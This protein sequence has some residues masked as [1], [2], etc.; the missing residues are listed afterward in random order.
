MAGIIKS[1]KLRVSMAADEGLLFLTSSNGDGLCS[2]GNGF[3]GTVRGM[4][5]AVNASLINN[6]L[7]YLK[8]FFQNFHGPDLLV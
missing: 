4:P 5:Y 3:R 8:S 2:I 7:A 1:D 6:C